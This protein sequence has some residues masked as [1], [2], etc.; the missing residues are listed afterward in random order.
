M[1]CHQF[2]GLVVGLWSRM[3][4]AGHLAPSYIHPSSNS[5]KAGAVAEEA[6]GDKLHLYAELNSTHHFMPLAFET[7]GVFSADSCPS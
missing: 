3:H 1:V 5:T 2:L 7:F 4:H 6:V